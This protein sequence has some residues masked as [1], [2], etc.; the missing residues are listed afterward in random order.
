MALDSRG[1]T[2]GEAGILGSNRVDISCASSP[3][4]LPQ[5]VTSR[6]EGAEVVGLTHAAWP[7]CAVNEDG[8]LRVLANWDQLSEAE[9]AVAWRRLVKRNKVWVA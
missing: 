5:C 1:P 4:R 3:L 6:R 8:T 2:I 7:S 9:R